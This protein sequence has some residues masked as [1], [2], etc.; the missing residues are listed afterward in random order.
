MESASVSKTEVLITGAL[1]QSA[2]DQFKN[3]PKLNITYLPDCDRSSLLQAA[4][5]AQVLVTRSETDVDRE[6]I[7]HATQLRVIARAAV[8]VG[9]IDINYA[10]ER[11][12]LVINCPGKNTNSAAEL[13]MGLLLSMVRNLPQAHATVK[14]GGWDRGTPRS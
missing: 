5:A 7:D 9:N 1:H 6:V 2:L 3:H 4:S 8:G 13:T 12:I 10:S 14:G 11:G